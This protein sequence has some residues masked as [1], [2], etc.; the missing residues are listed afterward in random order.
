VGTV[1]GNLAGLAGGVQHCRASR[2]LFADS[3]WGSQGK[4]QT[5]SKSQKNSQDVS[6]KG[7]GKKKRTEK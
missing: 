7:V 4:F 1:A 5:Y 2:K 3:V 6:N